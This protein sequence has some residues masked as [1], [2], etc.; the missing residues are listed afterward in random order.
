[1]LNTLT[2]R[3]QTIQTL[4]QNYLK[5]M[6]LFEKYYPPLFELFSSSGNQNIELEVSDSGEVFVIKDG[7]KVED[8]RIR[9]LSERVEKFY[10]NPSRITKPT[11]EVKKI[12]RKCHHIH[13]L[14]LL[15]SLSVKKG[16]CGDQTVFNYKE[17]PLLMIFGVGTGFH[18]T[19]F[20]KISKIKY[21]ILVEEDIELLKASLY[22]MNWAELLS[23]FKGSDKELIILLGSDVKKLAEDV[24]KAIIKCHPMFSGFSFFF[25]ASNSELFE[26]LLDELGRKQFLLYHGWGFFDDEI[27]SVVQTMEKIVKRVPVFSGRKKIEQE[28][29]AFIVGS[30]PSLDNTIEIIRKW[31]DKAVIFSCGTGLKVLKEANIRPDFHIELERPKFTYDVLLDS[32]SRDVLKTLNMIGSN[33]LYP[34]VLDLAGERTIFLKDSDAGSTLFSRFDYKQMPLSSPTVTNSALSI[35]LMAGFQHICFFGVDLGWRDP[36]QHHSNMSAYFDSHNK[37]SKFDLNWEWHFEDDLGRIYTTGI[38]SWTKNN[39]EQLIDNFPHVKIFQVGNGAAIKGA[40]R[41]LNEKEILLPKNINKKAVLQQFVLNRTTDYKSKLNLKKA[42]KQT[43]KNFY[44]LTD[45]ILKQLNRKIRNRQDFINVACSINQ[46]LQEIQT[47]DF[48]AYIL[49]RGSLWHIDN[50]IYIKSHLILDDKKSMEFLIAATDAYKNFIIKARDVFTK[51][52]N[53]NKNYLIKGVP[54]N[55]DTYYFVD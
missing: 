17:L 15:D 36:K 20:N 55:E 10:K 6:H 29:A 37:L 53:L 11:D 16:A 26:E 24:L 48:L 54:H 18:V 51:V 50:F 22:T 49:L 2:L 27:C 12:Q 25:K 46:K 43:K 34:K 47:K 4:E 21:L 19:M 40:K 45:F 33:P 28:S 44:K 8:F 3:E 5:N 30:G 7:K 42:L 32:F 23:S 38:F 35:A 39:I 41:A 52:Y 13:T 9:Q 31:Q 1:M 14:K